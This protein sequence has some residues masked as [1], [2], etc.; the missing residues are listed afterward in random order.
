MERN[1][2]FFCNNDPSIGLR[3]R[4]PVAGPEDHLLNCFIEKKTHDKRN[5]SDLAIFVEPEIL[6]GYPDLVIAK[7][8]VGKY[9]GW[10]DERLKLRNI[11]IKILYYMLICNHVTS[12][13]CCAQLGMTKGALLD[14]L[15]NLL[16]AKLIARKNFEWV[17]SQGVTDNLLISELISVEAK[18]NNWKKV[19]EQASINMHF[20]NSSYVL[21]PTKKPS[22]G[23][24]A[25]ARNIGIGIYSCSDQKVTRI[26][27]PH[28]KRGVMSYT[29]LLFNEWLGRRI[30]TRG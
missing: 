24:Q 14:C 20:A 19:F 25:H 12:S 6:S 10:N 22:D 29:S 18:I 4:R 27:T 1:I 26:V 21:T 2:L 5:K 8:D 11:D 28:R 3:V 9:C 15:E 30:Y 16:D 23:I 17:V 13:Q 7:Y